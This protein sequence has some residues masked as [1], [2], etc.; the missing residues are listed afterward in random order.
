LTDRFDDDREPADVLPELADR[1]LEAAPGEEHL[2]SSANYLVLAAVVEAVTGRSFPG[3]LAEQV[4]EP[5]GMDQAVTTPGRA[6]DRVPPGHRFVLGH[7]RPFD[8]PYDPAGAAYG[9]LGGSLEDA[10]AFA[11]AHLGDSDALL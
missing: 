8:S 7:P 9:Y 6:A 5:A 4:L 11:Q 1:D 10:V 3:V 2:Y